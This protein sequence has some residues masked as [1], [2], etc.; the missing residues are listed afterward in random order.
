MPS[1]C[2]SGLTLFDTGWFI[3]NPHLTD[4]ASELYGHFSRNPTLVRPSAPCVNVYLN[5]DLVAETHGERSPYTQIIFSEK[6]Y[7]QPSAR[8]EI[9]EEFVLSDLEATANSREYVLFLAPNRPTPPEWSEYTTVKEKSVLSRLFFHYR[10]EAALRLSELIEIIA[11]N[12][13]DDD[14]LLPESLE[15]AANFFIEHQPPYS[16]FG[17]IAAGNDGVVSVEWR[18][19]MTLPPD[20]RWKNCD[21]ILSMRFLPSGK[22]T[23]VGETREVGDESPF[24]EI[25]EEPHNIAYSHVAP[26]FNYLRLF[27]D[28]S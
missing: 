8:Y 13:D 25:G 4:I 17:T 28:L 26:F 27:D 22:I 23:F 14:V 5:P 2:G 10:E 21:G 16:P 11:E 3:D 18:L 15:Y 19:P 1:P 7:L 6:G 24:F 20:H 12:P 9:R